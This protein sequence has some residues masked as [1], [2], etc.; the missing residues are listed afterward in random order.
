[1]IRE[2]L[3]VQILLYYNGNGFACSVLCLH[4]SCP[5]WN[6]SLWPG[7]FKTRE[8]PI[9]IRGVGRVVPEL[10]GLIDWITLKS[11]FQGE[12][13]N[14][15][16]HDTSVINYEMYSTSFNFREAR[17]FVIGSPE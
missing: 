17:L 3:D 12:D 14:E 15:I 4:R 2:N 7:C 8:F 6:G 9:W 1:M 10:D 16:M 11:V 5:F 13:W